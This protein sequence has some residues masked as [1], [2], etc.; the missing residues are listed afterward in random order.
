MRYYSK[1]K[2]I[3]YWEN[4]EKLKNVLEKTDFSDMSW[5]DNKLIS[6]AIN[7]TWDSWNI[8]IRELWL[9]GFYQNY[10]FHPGHSKKI[11]ESVALN[12]INHTNRPRYQ[13]SNH[14]LVFYKEPTWGDPNTIDRIAS[15]YPRSSFAQNMSSP[16]SLFKEE[17]NDFQK[18]RNNIIHC[19][20]GGMKEL[21]SHLAYRKYNDY[22]NKQPIYYL[23]GNIGASSLFAYQDILESFNSYLTSVYK[24][25]SQLFNF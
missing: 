17:I 9:I 2:R 5:E 25:N 3:S 12:R 19:S 20:N 6:G 10:L 11:E 13:S 23:K 24:N 21:N 16:L 22:L 18:I 15:Y 1:K 14:N 8:L 7:S 4:Q